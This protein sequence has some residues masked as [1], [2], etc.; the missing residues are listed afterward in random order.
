[1]QEIR[2]KY[3][4]TFWTSMTISVNQKT[5]LHVDQGNKRGSHNAQLCLGSF[6]KNGGGGTWMEE[7]DGSGDRKMKVTG[8]ADKKD[9]IIKYGEGRPP[10]EI[11]V[12]ATLSGKV[13][14]T[15]RSL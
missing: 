9:V 13:Y 4:D 8:G 10:R 14:S 3:E 5:C 12:G 6:N 1:M 15:Y 11:K 2:A 7:A